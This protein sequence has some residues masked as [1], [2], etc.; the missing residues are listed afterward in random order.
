[1]LQI[2]LSAGYAIRL[3]TQ[4]PRR[5]AADERYVMP[6]TLGRLP[7][8]MRRRLMPDCLAARHT[9]CAESPLRDYAAR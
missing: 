8:L 6:S 2:T 4:R 5:H 3:F 9:P 1:M 7:W